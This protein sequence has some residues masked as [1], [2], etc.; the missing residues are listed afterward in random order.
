METPNNES[1]ERV[2]RCIFCGNSSLSEEHIWPR[3]MHG[4]LRKRR[5][6]KR[7]VAHYTV[8]GVISGIKSES[9]RIRD[10]D[11]LTKR[12]KVVCAPCNN[13]WMS[14]IE[15]DAKPIL[16]L[17]INGEE[18]ILD[19]QMLRKLAT[20]MALKTMVGESS[21]PPHAIVT[22]EERNEFKASGTIPTTMRIWAGRCFS[23]TWHAAWHRST[24]TLGVSSDDAAPITVLPDRENIQ[25]TTLG[26]GELY[27]YARVLQSEEVQ[28]DSAAVTEYLVPIFPE[29]LDELRLPNR[30]IVSEKVANMI[31]NGL[32]R[33]VRTLAAAEYA[34]DGSIIT[35][36]RPTQSI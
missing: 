33:A 10:G 4:L 24:G 3:W 1:I 18:G 26:A 15:E 13:T 20:W 35:R 19:R 9:K 16:T 30:F 27:L 22:Q 6:G 17:L 14:K 31:A 32:N 8:G 12:L 25:T 34:E 5:A 29:T 7:N 23:P 11:V 36:P 28:L 2:K 21:R